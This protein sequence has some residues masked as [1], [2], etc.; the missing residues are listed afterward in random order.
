MLSVSLREDDK[1]ELEEEEEKEKYDE[2]EDRSSHSTELWFPRWSANSRI[3][4]SAVA[5][6][7]FQYHLET[8][9]IATSTFL[10]LDLFHF[11][12]TAWLNILHDAPCCITVVTVDDI[13]FRK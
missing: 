7:P 9:P 12:D 3:N 2:E 5:V 8:S 13:F 10:I 11:A 6:P 1:E 4:C